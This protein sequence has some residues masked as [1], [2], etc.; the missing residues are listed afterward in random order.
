MM[1]LLWICVW[2]KV[3]MVL[4]SVGGSIG[5]GVVVVW[6]YGVMVIK[7]NRVRMGRDCIG[8][9]FKIGLGLWVMM[10]WWFDDVWIV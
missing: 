10:V 7:V 3:V 1:L 2:L 9:G 5:W 8:M 6:L 4:V